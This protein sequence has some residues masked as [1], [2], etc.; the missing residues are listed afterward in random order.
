M[1]TTAP[2]P[3]TTL[4]TP[5]QRLKERASKEPG[6]VALRVKNRG[7]W[8]EIHLS[9]VRLTHRHKCLIFAPELQ[10]LDNSLHP[11]RIERAYRLKNVSCHLVTSVRLSGFR[12]P[13]EPTL[14]GTS[15]P[16]Q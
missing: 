3:T 9:Q 6:G 14:G 10:A 5:A 1:T 7:I 16:I 15:A 2:D 13:L 11:V 4:R 12:D 8:R